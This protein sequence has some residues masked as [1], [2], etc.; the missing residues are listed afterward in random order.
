MHDSIIHQYKTNDSCPFV[1]IRSE[2]RCIL[3]IFECAGVVRNSKMRQVRFYMLSLN[4]HRTFSCKDLYS[5]LNIRGAPAENAG[6]RT[7]LHFFQFG[8]SIDLVHIYV[9]L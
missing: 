6:E 4:I 8:M 2:R 5:L 3:T 9:Y 1:S 7:Y